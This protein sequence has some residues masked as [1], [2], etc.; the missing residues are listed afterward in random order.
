MTRSLKDELAILKAAGMIVSTALPLAARKHPD[1]N[2]DPAVTT[3]AVDFRECDRAV[4]R[5][6]CGRCAVCG[7]QKHTAIHGPLCG[8]PPGSK[9][10]GHRFVPATK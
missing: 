10:W 3:G 6:R 5:C 2:H 7:N 1:P 8:Q 9:P 4:G